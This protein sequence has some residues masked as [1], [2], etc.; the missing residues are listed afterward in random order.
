MS[1]G[2]ACERCGTH[3]Y[4]PSSFDGKCP[5]CRKHKRRGSRAELLEALAAA[6]H[7][8]LAQAGFMGGMSIL[9][10]Q[11]IRD[12]ARETVKQIDEA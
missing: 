6:K 2:P 12:L 1:A 10:E 9:N 7:C 5:F 11:Q 8:I 3:S 4:E